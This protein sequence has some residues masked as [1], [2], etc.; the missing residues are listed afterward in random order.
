M[1]STLQWTIFSRKTDA[2][3]GAGRTSLEIGP[4]RECADFRHERIS[5][6][7]RQGA[8]TGKSGGQRGWRCP[9]GGVGFRWTGSTKSLP[10]FPSPRR[11]LKARVNH[12]SRQYCRLSDS[13]T[14]AIVARWK[15]AD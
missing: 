2:E 5:R 8:A 10:Q 13:P 4:D 11:E 7:R 1:R 14:L 12:K 9:P 3:L 6:V 15:W